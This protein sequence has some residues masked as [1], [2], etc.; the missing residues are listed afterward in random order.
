[1]FGRGSLAQHLLLGFGGVAV[2]LAMLAQLWWI[3]E[4]TR[5]GEAVDPA[6]LDALVVLAARLD[7]AEIAIDQVWLLD[8]GAPG[9]VAIASVIAEVRALRR[10][11]E[12]RGASTST[13]WVVD[14]ET[15]L[16]ELARML[17]AVA[18]TPEAYAE[19][20]AK[21]IEAQATVGIASVAAHEMARAQSATFR[22]G[23]RIIAPVTCVLLLLAIA[24][25]V[26]A[27]RRR[28]RELVRGRR[29]QVVTPV[30]VA[31]TTDPGLDPLTGLLNQH[32]FTREL[33]AR[34]CGAGAIAVHHV[35]VARFKSI[36]ARYGYAAG[37]QL[38]R[39]FADRLRALVREDDIVA[40][41]GGDDFAV[42]QVEAS[43]GTAVVLARRLAEHSSMP[44]RLDHELT[45]VPTA[46][47]GTALSGRDGD[48]AAALTAAA[49]AAQ[50]RDQETLRAEAAERRPLRVVASS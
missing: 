11:L 40:R 13:D 44:L 29:L 4:A 46:S 9:E 48:C 34:L 31:P 50:R 27:E 15:G 49:A 10:G 5:V 16:E 3:K 26:V 17:P 18:S 1:M 14:V 19:A 6:T 42:L 25:V 21:L 28:L 30:S 43:A 23:F 45:I 37:D 8:E 2:V 7:A 22:E 24:A 33:N 35:D 32:S 38:L 41:I 36:N 39:A 47:I 20:R 12:R